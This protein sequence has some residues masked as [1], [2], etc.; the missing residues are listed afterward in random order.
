MDYGKQRADPTRPAPAAIAD[1]LS[2]IPALYS[3]RMRFPTKSVTLC[4]TTGRLSKVAPA[5]AGNPVQ[6]E[7]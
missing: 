7:E 4:C 1:A 5:A 6:A 3:A 2:K